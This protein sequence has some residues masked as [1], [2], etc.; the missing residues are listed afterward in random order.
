MKEIQFIVYVS[1][2]EKSTV[3]YQET[4]GIRPSLYVP[5]M[6]EFT[7]KPHVKIGLMPET[8]IA[9]ILTDKTKHPST[10]N[11][12]PRCELYLVVDNAK[13][14]IER[15]LEAGGR[16]VSQLQERDWGDK[17]GYLLDLD[18]HVLAFAEKNQTY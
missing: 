5:G 11:G 4:L 12:I 14:Y 10:G 13:A 2:Q 6:T 16:L 8:G 17:V 18:G 3:F 7:L 1:N 15:G 9:K